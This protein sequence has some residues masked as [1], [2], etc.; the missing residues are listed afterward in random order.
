MDI[1][2]A[3][4]ILEAVEQ[5]PVDAFL[6]ELWTITAS[7]PFTRG[8]RIING[9]A[10]VEVRP[11]I[12]DRAHAVHISDIM[13]LDAGKRLGYGRDALVILLHLA[14]KHQVIL[15]LFAKAYAKGPGSNIFPKTNALVD[16]YRHYGFKRKGGEM[17]RAPGTAI[18]TPR[19]T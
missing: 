7:H 17:V 5:T 10:T 11:D 14:D 15:T 2:Q 4:T 19:Q 3:L 16:W 1:R 13:S 12:G 6:D 18:P 8:Q 9:N